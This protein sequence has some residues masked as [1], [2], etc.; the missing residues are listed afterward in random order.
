M[1]LVQIGYSFTSL[2]PKWIKLYSY[3]FQLAGKY[4][5]RVPVKRLNAR[6]LTKYLPAYQNV[7]LGCGKKNMSVKILDICVN[8]R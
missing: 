4:V 7:T 5:V 2:L 1:E 8:V 3:T 6:I